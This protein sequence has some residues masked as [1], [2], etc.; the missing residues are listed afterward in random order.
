MSF[1]LAL[2]HTLLDLEQAEMPLEFLLDLLFQELQ[3]LQRHEG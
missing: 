3:S 1:D 2:E